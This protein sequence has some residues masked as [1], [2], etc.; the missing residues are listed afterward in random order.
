MLATETAGAVSAA[1]ANS[2]I[3]LG[4]PKYLEHHRE[5]NGRETKRMSGHYVQDDWEPGGNQ[6]NR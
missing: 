2:C 1:P 5:S 6:D 3:P 4:Y